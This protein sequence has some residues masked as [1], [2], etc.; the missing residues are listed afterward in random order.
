MSKSIVFS[1]LDH[2]GIREGNF[3]DGDLWDY[4]DIAE[5]ISLEGNITAAFDWMHYNIALTEDIYAISGEDLS[6]LVYNISQVDY[7]NDLFSDD[8][9][10]YLLHHPEL[11]SCKYFDFRLQE[12]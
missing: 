11:L 10:E 9:E 4:N 1:V 5:E 7:S 2:Q 6:I 3:S 12:N 8:P